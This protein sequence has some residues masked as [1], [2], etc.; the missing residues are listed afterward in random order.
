[1][2]IL[3]TILLVFILSISAVASLY[4][5]QE[6]SAKNGFSRERTAVLKPLNTL[7]LT[8]NSYYIT[9]LTDSG[10][11]LGNRTVK[12]KFSC[13]YDLKG[14][15]VL[16]ATTGNAKKYQLPADF[17]KDRTDNF[18]VDGFTCYN[19]TAGRVFFTYYYRNQFLCLDTNMNVLY[20]GTTIDT[21]T[22]AKI[23]LA[24]Y[25]ADGKTIR[26]MAKP[27]LMVNKKGY[28]DGNYYYNEA[29]LAGDNEDRRTF[30]K[31]TVLDVYKLDNGGKYSHSLYLPNYKDKQLTGFAVRGDLLMAIYDRYLVS[32]SLK[33]REAPTK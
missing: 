19:K 23:K 28:S 2:K 10:I 8:Y 16:P 1:M 7:D 6:T 24:E 3:Y 13:G 29:A 14:L 31:H 20:T 12:E 33:R 17:F 5:L 4:F 26:T 15:Q 30:N 22:I 11:V 18:S 21:N 25:E 32:Y 9:T 27:A